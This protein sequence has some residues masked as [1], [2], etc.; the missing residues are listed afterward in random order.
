MI[1]EIDLVSGKY[2]R[3]LEMHHLFSSLSTV[4]CWWWSRWGYWLPIIV[5]V[6]V[7]LVLFLWIIFINDQILY[8]KCDSHKRFHCHIVISYLLDF[9]YVYIWIVTSTMGHWNFCPGKQANGKSGYVLDFKY[10]LNT[11]DRRHKCASVY[12]EP[13]LLNR[14]SVGASPFTDT[15]KEDTS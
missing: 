3:V 6:A 14:Y 4:V 2:T 13:F 5:M 1:F 15:K 12:I 10:L 9:K 7:S 8:W 11:A